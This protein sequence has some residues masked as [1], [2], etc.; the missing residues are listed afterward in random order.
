M[1]KITIW[2]SMSKTR[3]YVNI[4]SKPNMNIIETVNGICKDRLKP[5]RGF[6]NVSTANKLWNLWIIYYNF[7]KLHYSL[8]MKT[9]A[10][11]CKIKLNLNKNKWLSLINRSVDLNNIIEEG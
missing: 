7:I 8:N 4:K 11:G 10:E 1:K 9:P 5:M 3:P 2:I 6:R